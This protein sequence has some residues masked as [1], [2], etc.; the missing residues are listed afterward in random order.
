MSANLAHNHKMVSGNY[1]LSELVDVAHSNRRLTQF[2]VECGAL[3]PIGATD[4]QGRG[5]PRRFSRD[6]AIVACLLTAFSRKT[7]IGQ[8]LQFSEGMRSKMLTLG[9]TRELI[10]AAIMGNKKVFVCVLDDLFINVIVVSDPDADWTFKFF[11]DMAKMNK[12]GTG[13][14]RI[15][16]INPWLEALRR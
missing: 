3:K 9:P 15:V 13:N 16:F 5:N 2:W 14:R 4:R 10:E 1:G 8:L 11:Q 7:T 12:R 6:E